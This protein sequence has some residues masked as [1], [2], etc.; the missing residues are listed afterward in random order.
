MAKD[1][2]EAKALVTSDGVT[3]EVGLKAF[4]LG[5]KEAEGPRLWTPSRQIKDPF[6]K[7]EYTKWDLAPPPLGPKSLE[8]LAD[9]LLDSTD[10]ATVVRQI[11]T[12]V[13]GLGYHFIPIQKGVEN[14]QDRDKVEHF[15]EECNPDMTFDEISHNTNMDWE[16]LGNGYI[17]A[18]RRANI[19]ENEVDRLEHMP[20][21][22]CRWTRDKKNVVQKIGGK[23]VWFRLFGSDPTAETSRA[24]FDMKHAGL[25]RG[26]VLNEVIPFQHYHPSSRHYGIPW[27]VPALAAVRG[28]Q[29]QADRNLQF[30][31][32]KT[33]PEWAIWIEGDLTGKDKELKV[34]RE[35]IENH[36]KLVLSG[37]HYRVLYLEVPQ[38]V[39]LNF[40]KMAPE[41]KDADHR[42]YR[43]DNRDEILRSAAM[44]P[45]RVGVIET[46]NIGAGTG[47]TQIEVYKHSIIKPRQEKWEKKML[48]LI[49]EGLFVKTYRMKFDEIDTIDEQREAAILGILAATPFLKINEGREYITKFLKMSLEPIDEEWA[50]YPFQI[51]AAQ[52]AFL[53]LGLGGEPVPEEGQ[54]ITPMRALAAMSFPNLLALMNPRTQEKVVDMYKRLQERMTNATPVTV[55]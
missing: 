47:E 34:F 13:T 33:L 42:Q 35:N 53:D 46:G 51:I 26:D 55:G 7:K 16:A 22:D 52:L 49:R 38:G 31:L 40:Q 44:L 12:D 48:R 14:P 36:F 21:K 17:E 2:G 39:K 10:Y 20:G 37:Q 1:E 29:F 8:T 19:P 50:D 3:T 23:E 18:T 28:N 43:I 4:S 15:F 27:I 30:F 54:Q 32:N 5:P 11:A 6:L 9:L 45:H 24:R 41:I 25:E